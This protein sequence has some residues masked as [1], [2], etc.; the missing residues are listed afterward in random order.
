MNTSPI[1]PRW[2]TTP[3]TIDFRPTAHRLP[4]EIDF[5]V[6][7]GGFTGLAAAAWLRRIAPEKTVA[8]LESAV[9]GAGASG[10]TGGLALT[11]TAAGDMP[12]LGDVLGGFSETLRELS[13][14]CD[15][16]LP[17]VW[18][19]ARHNPLP[20][21]PI[22]WTDS[23]NL[24][25]VAEVPGGTIDPGKMVSGLARSAEQRGALIFE[26]ARVDDVAFGEIVRLKIGDQHVR[27]RGVLF[28][29]NAQSLEIS[30]LAGT[31]EPKFTL[32]TATKP[33]TAAQIADL[34]LSSGKPFYTVEMPYL[35]GR[36]L[37]GGRIIFGAGLVH[38]KNWRELDSLDVA[39]GEPLAMFERFEQRVR[40]F[41]PVL[42]DVQF[43]HRWGGPILVGAGWDM[44]PIFR[45]HSGSPHALVLGAYSGHGVALSV[46]L[47]R[48]AAEALLGQREPPK[49]DTAET[50]TA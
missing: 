19:L 35:W 23:G 4:T 36:L 10:H 43:T 25:A 16:H 40:K 45:R 11:E 34:G 14:D 42:R 38:L 18:E 33:F 12:G 8:L 26:H 27:A 3:W 31:T 20:H 17:G 15:L 13:V 37:S 2:G 7:G 44:R 21:S 24:R 49:W 32:A 28:A 46:Y 29:C 47:G 48:W 5:A 50:R 6:I 22:A 1:P 39:A 41:H 30:G 9:I